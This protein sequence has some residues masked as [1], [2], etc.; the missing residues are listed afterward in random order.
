MA[1]RTMSV[2]QMTA[3]KKH[4][5]G[6]PLL[7][8]S[9]L[10]NGDDFLDLFDAALADMASSR[11][12]D[13]AKKR[14][15][16]VEAWDRVGRTIL[17]RVV[18]GTYGDHGSVRDLQTGS[19]AHAITPDQAHA[20]SLRCM[21]LCPPGGLTALLFV[22]HGQ[23]R[24]AATAVLARFKQHWQASQP[25]VTLGV[26]SITRGDVWVEAADLE[27]VTAVSYGHESDLA[28]AGIPKTLGD[29][30]LRIEPTKGERALSRALKAALMDKNI[31][32]AQLLG[33]SDERL[34]E[35]RV[36][37]GDGS[38][39]RTFVLG[40]ER[41]PSMQYILSEANDPTPDD[42]SL[43]SRVSTEAASLFTAVGGSWQTAWEHD[44]PKP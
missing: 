43:R 28:D 40:K 4:A 18:V 15:T 9:K 5:R 2:T 29:L 39:R 7:D 34:D 35:V 24:S 31:N 20:V 42:A 44:P 41:A 32:R 8:L 30:R 38:Q 12:T 1:Y 17:M 13:D 3:R 6:V 19:E 10:P 25:D 21:L 11:I 26:E 36:T 14:Y 22:E 23:G 27:S 16:E 33:F 37:L